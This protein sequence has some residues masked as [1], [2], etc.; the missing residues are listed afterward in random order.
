M[1]KAIYYIAA[2]ITLLL[3]ACNKFT[4]I[5][6]KGVN[7]LSTVDQ[8]DLLL[9]YNF[10]AQTFF[11]FDDVGVIIN[12]HYP[13]VTNVVTTISSPT[14]SLNYAYLTYDETVDRVTLTPSDVRY[15]GIYNIIDNIDNVIL[16]KADA[17]TGDK[18]K[19]ARLKAE[20]YIERAYFHYLLVN[21]FAKAYNP[22]TAATDGGIPYVLDD[23]LSKQNDK[24][25]VAQDYQNMIA[26]IN[27]A[28]AL[29][30]LPD[31]P[32]NNMRVGNGFAYAV[33]ARVLLSMGDYANAL[34]AANASLAIN[35]SIQDLRPL[36]TTGF[37]GIVTRAPLTPV[38]NLFYAAASAGGPFFMS[39]STEF[40]ATY[41]EPGNLFNN[42]Y[43]A[44]AMYP[45]SNP[46]IGIPTSR[47]WYAQTFSTNMAGLC[48]SD[49]YFAKAE[50][51]ARRATGTDLAD[52]TAI[53]NTF[54]QYRIDPA[55][56]QPLPNATSTAQAMAYLM[57]VVRAEN[58]ATYKDFFDIKRWNTETAYQQTITRT[59]S[60]VTYSLKPNSPLY[61]F[62]F[63]QNATTYNTSLTQNY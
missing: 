49:V 8:L 54:R 57:K 38:D 20:A 16:E 36:A 11:K 58:F 46:I 37:A 52:A 39:F 22:A 12:D 29:N 13:Y 7:L 35:S 60:G 4:E 40:T 50:C 31:V 1:K 45:G 51:L 43:P 53:V 61:I 23:D 24:L 63:P 9:N 48:T 55:V 17:A 10:G 25:T 34:I 62:P 44:G 14:K 42:N 3:T 15:A 6:P 21:L 19:A 18:T 56:Y 27:A 47:F 26:D 5:T 41:F 2:G 30:S 33:K 28:F 32:A 59:I